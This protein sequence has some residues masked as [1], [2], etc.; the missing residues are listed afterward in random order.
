MTTA[1]IA[2]GMGSVNKILSAFG[3]RAVASWMLG[4][5][6]EE[7]A[8][9][10]VA[11]ISGALIPFV[12]FNYGKRDVGRM[13]AGLKA[14]YLMALVLM[15][16]MGSVIYC[17]PEIFLNLFKPMPEIERMAADAIRASVPA[18]PFGIIVTLGCGFFTGTGYSFFGMLTQLLRS[19]VFRVSAAWIFTTYLAFSH[20]WYFQSFAAVC[21]SIVAS[22]FL[23]FVYRR[24]KRIF[25][26]DAGPI[27]Q[28]KLNGGD[29]NC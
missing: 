4:L 29:I 3:H 16:T 10:F 19:I 20:I 9:N 26:Q 13:I 21:G 7:L 14:A 12:A 5:R 24:I 23:T 8:F 2:L 28:I 17:Y 22:L 15:C 27:S 25:A 6:V 11:G 18:Y 1:S